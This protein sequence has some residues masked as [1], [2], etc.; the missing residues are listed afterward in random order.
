MAVE[1]RRSGESALFAMLA[2]MTVIAAVLA[3]ALFRPRKESTQ[4]DSAGM[5]I[6]VSGDNV[7]MLDE[8]VEQI[9]R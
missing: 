7:L 8:P 9:Q 4:V 5:K 6:H 3:V 1:P 2:M